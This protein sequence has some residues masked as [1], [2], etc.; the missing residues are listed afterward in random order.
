MTEKRSKGFG[1]QSQKV[2]EVSVSSVDEH[3]VVVRLEAADRRNALT[4]SLSDAI[5][6]AFD[7]IERDEDVRAVVLASAGTTFCAGAD[8]S[9]LRRA[10]DPAQAEAV[11]RTIYAA[12][13]RVQ[14][15]PLPTVAAVQG[16]A[17]GAGLNL[18]MACD[19]RIA[20]ISARFDSR[21][22]R[23]GLHP[24]GGSS[25]LLRSTVGRATAT[26]MLLFD[27]SIGGEHAE[28]VGLAWRCVP[29]DQ[30]VPAAIRLARQAARAPGELA[31]CIK[32][33]IDDAGSAP[34]QARAIEIELERQLWSFQQPW[35]A[36][37]SS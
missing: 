3:V 33:T 32:S 2:S 24:G 27:E 13:I 20:G 8:L 25:R 29:D 18:A 5:V 26:A 12:F 1:T 37:R 23:L 19:L 15:S 10:T 35:F 30:V 28:R 16:P 22:V 21:F 6:T 9:E 7:R 4:P 11:L 17:V 14:T 31:R 34:T 36:G